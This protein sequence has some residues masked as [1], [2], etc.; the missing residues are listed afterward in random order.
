MGKK[1]LNYSSI[2]TFFPITVFSQL[3]RSLAQSRVHSGAGLFKMFKRTMLMRHRNDP[4]NI[5]PRHH[6]AYQMH[7][8]KKPSTAQKRPV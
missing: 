1:F 2:L 8:A 3:H 4:R 5:M 6:T 7:N